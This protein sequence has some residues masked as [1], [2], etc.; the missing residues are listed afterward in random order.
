MTLEAL[1]KYVN[2]LEIC[3]PVEVAGWAYCMNLAMVAHA[4]G[5]K[6]VLEIGQ[7]WGWSSTAFATAIA[8]R[9]DAHIDSIDSHP[10]LKPECAEYI[11]TTGV[12]YD[13]KQ[14]SSRDFAPSKRYDL[15]YIDTNS[16]YDGMN[17]MIG[18][19]KPYLNE[20]GVL[21]LDGLLGEE[22][23]SRIVTEHR[24]FDYMPLFYC[25]KYGHAISIPATII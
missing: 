17:E 9:N 15:I 7:G 5:C 8:E 23:T 16:D 18:K 10:R 4:M 3:K 6:T 24:H 20:W 11:K 25:N 22:G 2:W 12:G 13:F 14:V 1:R 19:L 21:V